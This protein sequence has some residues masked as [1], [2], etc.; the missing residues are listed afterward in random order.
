M[1]KKHEICFLLKFKAVADLLWKFLL[2]CSIGC[3]LP[4]LEI[5]TFRNHPFYR[6]SQNHLK[7]KRSEKYFSNFQKNCNFESPGRVT[8]TQAYFRNI[9]WMCPFVNKALSKSTFTTFR[10]PMAP[11]RVNHTSDV[12]FWEVNII[13]RK[14]YDCK[15]HRV[16][17]ESRLYS[18]RLKYNSTPNIKVQANRIGPKK[19]YQWFS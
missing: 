3:M 8:Q 15:P 12:H 16:L 11:L 5:K 7:S 13:G 17:L 14:F 1:P 10:R 6:F 2:P 19:R 18:E 4:F 9:S